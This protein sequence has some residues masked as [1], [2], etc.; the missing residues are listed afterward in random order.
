MTV[1][2]PFTG[3]G[4]LRTAPSTEPQREIWLATR[5]GVDASL[6]F[7]ESVT[8]RFA[9]LVDFEA[10]RRA[11]KALV[12]RHEALR[13]TF[14]GDGLTLCIAQ[15]ADVDL[16]LIDCSR[17]DPSER[18]EIWK[19]SLTSAVEEPFDLEGGP[20]VRATMVRCG[21]DDH[22]LIF[23]IHHIVCDGWSTAVLV[24]DWAALYTALAHDAPVALAAPMPFSTYARERAGQLAISQQADDERYW[25]HQFASG[26]IP[27]LDLP[28]ERG[29]PALKTYRSRREDMF[30]DAV[31]VK[32]LKEFAIKERASLFTVLLAGFNVLIHRLTSQE[33]VIVGI[34][35]AGQSVDG[36]E[37]LVG[38]CVHLLPIRSRIDGTLTIREVVG[39]LRTRVLDGL[40][41]PH[42]TLGRLLEQ[43]PISRDTSR[44][45]LVSVIFNLDKG[46]ENLDFDGIRVEFSTNPRHLENFD[47]FLNAVEL[48]SGVALECQYN[49]D[50]FEA[51]TI[52]YWLEAYRC[53]LEGA[54]E[55]ADRTIGRLPLVP[56]SQMQL[57][58]QWNQT[59][60]EC[61]NVCVHQLVEAQ[62]DRTPDATAVEFKGCTISYRDL[63]R[64]ANHLAAR[65]RAAGVEPGTLVGLYV[66]RSIEMVVGILAIL[67]SGGGY[68]P[69]DPGYPADR[70]AFMVSDSGMNVLVTEN[71]R[72]QQLPFQVRT[73]LCVGDEYVSDP[74]GSR[75]DLPALDPETVAYVIYTSGSTGQ[76][77]G[78]LVPH[79]S[80]VNLLTSVKTR[81]GMTAAD[82]VLAITT[83]SFDIA[84]SELLLPLTVGARIV[85]AG[86]DVASDGV[87]LLRLIR[88]AGVTF[89]DATPSTWRLLLDAGW[90]GDSVK[91]ICTGEALPKDLA[92]ALVDRADSVWNGYGPTEATVWSTFHEV[93]KPVD[94][95]LIGSPIANTRIHILDVHGQPVPIGVPGEL[96]IGGAGVT[97]GYLNRPDLTRERFVDDVFSEIGGS[98]LYRTGD[99]ARYLGGGEIECLGR[100]DD[101]VKLR[102]FRIELGEIENV[103]SHHP[104]VVRVA[105]VAREDHPGDRRLVAYV[106]VRNAQEA[107]DSALRAHVQSTLPSYMIPAAFVRL[108]VFPLTPSGKID[109]RRLPAPPTESAAPIESFVAPRT[110]TEAMLADLWQQ[111]L[112]IGR[113]SVHDDFFALGGHSL[114]ASQILARLRRDHRIELLFR[115]MF[116]APTVA[117]LAQVVDAQSRDSELTDTAIERRTH[118]D[119]VRLSASQERIWLLEMMDP[120]Q[121]VAHNL[122]AAWRL[123]GPLCQDALQR[124]LDALV[125]RHETLRTCVTV[126]SG[127]PL[128]EVLPAMTIQ[129]AHLDLRSQPREHRD[130][131][132]MAFFEGATSQPFDLAVAPLFRA[133]LIRLDEDEHVLFILPHNLIW[134]G[135]SFDIFLKEL[136]HLYNGF[137]NDCPLPLDELPISYRDFSAWQREWLGGSRSAREAQWWRSQLQGDL[138]VLEL[139][140]DHDRPSESTRAGANTEMHLPNDEVDALI[141]VAHE[142]GGTLFTALFAVFCLLLHRLTGRD[143]LLVGTPVRARTRPETEGLIGPFMNIVAIR[144]QIDPDLQFVEFLARVRDVTLDSFSHQELPLEMVGIRPPVLNA[145]FSLQDARTRPTGF[146]D[147]QV[148]QL[149][150]LPP[151]SAAD[152]MLWTMETQNGLVGVLNYSQEL[153]EA[154]TIQRFMGRFRTLIS[155]VAR[156]PQKRVDELQLIPQEEHALID[157]VSCIR[158]DEVRLGLW[159]RFEQ[160]VEGTPEAIALVA[161][162]RS[163]SYAELNERANNLARALLDLGMTTGSRIAIYLDRSIELAVALF[164][165]MKT[166]G[167][168]ILLDPADP[169]PR[170]AS[171]LQVAGADLLITE[172]RLYAALPIRE[173]SILCV[174]EV[175]LA[176]STPALVAENASPADAACL[177]CSFDDNGRPRSVELSQQALSTL[178]QGVT[179]ELSLTSDDVITATAPPSL[180]VSVIELLVP[181]CAGARVV[182]AS[183]NVVAD[184]ERLA[185]EIKQT[186][187]TLMIA[188][189][190]LWRELLSARH[191]WTALKAVCIGN[192]PS[193]NLLTELASAT[194]AAWF[195]YGFPEAGIWSTAQR[196]SPPQPSGLL[197]RPLP[198]TRIRILG[199]DLRD[200]PFGSVGELCVPVS[201][202]I[203][204]HGPSGDHDFVVPADEPTELLYRSGTHVRWRFDGILQL[205]HARRGQVFSGGFRL[206]LEEPA[207]ALRRHSAVQDAAIVS[208]DQEGRSRLVGYI[209]RRPGHNYTD[210]E[211]RRELRRTLPERAIPRAFIEVNALSRTTTG[212]V[213]FRQFERGDH[214]PADES[215]VPH[216][217]TEQIMARLWREALG[218]EQVSVHDNF[219]DLGGY[220]LLCFQVLERLERETGHRLSPRLLLLDSLRQAAA[221]LDNVSPSRVAQRTSSANSA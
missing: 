156:N 52:R 135:W 53:L 136:S 59:A 91:A 86:R 128:Q 184:S 44:L 74:E 21:E 193:S 138:P 49:S 134:D 30:L 56:D 127:I 132:M 9:G 20:L 23:T 176:E 204:R 133:T 165:V 58:R 217:A 116:E 29:R 36:Y 153:F 107:T 175:D 101:Q 169:A 124:S 120:H 31:L 11:L 219:F 209:V 8:L 112:G 166:R 10:M 196:L 115:K 12:Q 95:I 155:D 172:K 15:S 197:G 82:V 85:L 94:R 102:G 18:G 100:N 122:P 48:K 142:A 154:S 57:L 87:Q 73:V 4:I 110:P 190:P 206:N 68:V 148:R 64:R 35:I 174:D 150:V 212:S 178:I 157:D 145:F 129:L 187:T 71:G 147:L 7:N 42:I 84:V 211:L 192:P 47:V 161:G 195:M 180:D 213:D 92:V 183:D 117:L 113:V 83:L 186:G 214:T 108:D 70:L 67:K 159:T 202:A 208:R 131:A 69:L 78:V 158:L 203:R 200:A 170:L 151:A 50:L 141:R 51:A 189:S 3:A 80:V 121:R 218:L 46:I 14:S 88:T 210:S 160:V 177:L 5:V 97:K 54:A 118:A 144:S 171:M 179:K 38:H 32:R 90:D 33:D 104:A 191:D 60:A 77:K 72:H 114:L 216:S 61:P 13:M 62:V 109:R 149:H 106:V 201:T 98:K 79:R 28:S 207:A 185:G 26:D 37:R 221:H 17:A 40:E 96:Y 22:R 146:G 63:E 39:G 139:P 6:A 16:A 105:A 188:A 162:V 123:S 75:V 220:S 111:A 152:L 194:A 168:W 99:N 19:Q 205:I 66:E 24:R 173:V 93:T 27:V 103:L 34:P 163:V 181:L 126:K 1:H 140:T 41:H 119:H 215:V 182:L 81:P 55:S 2:N 65:L 164:A 76:P 125:V 89:I 43:L 167:A 137:A 143:D 130:A 25:T 198:G 45:P 199:P